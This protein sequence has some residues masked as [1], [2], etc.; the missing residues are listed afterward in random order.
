MR[1]S[2]GVGGCRT[3]MH[4]IGSFINGFIS[5]Q[6][7]MRDLLSAEDGQGMVEYALILVLIAVVVI[8]VLVLLGNQVRNVFCNISG[9]LTGN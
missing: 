6:Q 4:T 9:G 8:V 5:I 3:H 2:A 1:Y 7:R